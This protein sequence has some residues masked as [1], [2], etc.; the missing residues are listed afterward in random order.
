MSCFGILIRLKEGV[1]D[2]GLEQNSDISTDI[3]VSNKFEWLD[4]PNSYQILK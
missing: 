3:E 4:R 1:L 2:L